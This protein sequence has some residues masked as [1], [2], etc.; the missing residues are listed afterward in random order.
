MKNLATASLTFTV[1]PMPGSP[2]V[3]GV[4]VVQDV[5]SVRVKAGGTGTHRGAVSCLLSGVTAPGGLVQPPVGVPPAPTF[6]FTISGSSLKV[7]VDGKKALLEG[8]F[9]VVNV[10]LVSPS[11]V[12]SA[13]P[14]KVSV[15]A[16]G[17]TKVRGT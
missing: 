1:E 4:A 5:A 3:G 7:L 16:A 2:G 9:A 10:P 15:S 8:D 13:A 11:G 12:A 17:Q 14:M 6:A